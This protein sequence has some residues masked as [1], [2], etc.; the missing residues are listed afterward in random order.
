MR[1]FAVTVAPALL[2]ACAAFAPEEADMSSAL[3]DKLPAEVPQARCAPAV[4]AVARPE[5]RPMYDTAQMAYTL[6]PH[7][8]AYFARHQWA[9]TPGQML[10][11]LLVRTIERTGCFG[12]VLA[13]PGAGATHMLRADIVELV[14][15]FSQE[16]PVLRLDLR[17]R[18][19]VVGSA[20]PP[21]QRTVSVTEPMRQ[22]GPLAGVD[23]ANDAVAR[24]LQ[25]TA[26]FV[27]EQMR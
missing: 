12:V 17:V 11:P 1:W 18:L 3:L 21:V 10:H 15:D 4:L 20:R 2:A 6:R 26:A 27:L 14:Q 7:Q 16:P 8:V 25:Q 23:S 24:A 9:E 22:K 13:Q 19:D 5:V